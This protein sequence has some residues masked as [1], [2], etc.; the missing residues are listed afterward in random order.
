MNL[1]RNPEFMRNVWL[2]LSP[3]RLLMMPA[4]LGLVFLIC[5]ESPSN[6]HGQPLLDLA[7]V[8]AVLLVGITVFWGTRLAAEGIADEFEQG[9]WDAQRLC[10]LSPWQMSLGKLFGGP[11]YAWYGG[12]FCAAADVGGGAFCAAAYVGGAHAGRL[13]ALKVVLVV[14]GIALALHAFVILASLLDWRRASGR[15]KLRGGSFL[16]LILFG[17]PLSRAFSEGLSHPV[18]WYGHDY[19]GIDFA[20]LC[21]ACAVFWSVL[22]LYR[23]MRAEL[24]FQQSPAAWIAFLLFLYFFSGGWFYGAGATLPGEGALAD[25]PPAL[26]HLVLCGLIGALFSY[27]MLFAERKDWIR[28][29]RMSAL[30]RAGQP[31]RAATLLPRWLATLALALLTGLLLAAWSLAAGPAQFGFVMAGA[32][33]SWLGFLLRDASVV[34]LCNLGRDQRR[35]DG[36]ALVLLGVLYLLLPMLLTVLGLKDALPAVLPMLS[37]GHSAWFLAGPLQAALGLGLLWSRW[38]RLPG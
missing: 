23:A 27:A 30:L 15:R 16:L 21:A 11:V 29:R 35:S 25:C 13:E 3:Q 7:A 37:Y 17:F 34:L 36:A 14:A 18:H 4:I 32:A 6:A 8:A 31:G 33:L 12:A 22:G 9:T 26:A 28:L 5:L 19:A 24:A 2:E 10:S 1:L 20:L 38:R